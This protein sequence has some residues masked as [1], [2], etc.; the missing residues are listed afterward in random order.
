MKSS[1]FYQIKILLLLSLTACSGENSVTNLTNTTTNT[2][3]F[4]KVVHISTANSTSL[5]FYLTRNDGTLWSLGFETGTSSAHNG[6]KQVVS[7]NNVAKSA[8]NGAYVLALKND[9]TLWSWGNNA[10]GNLGDG[11]TNSVDVPQVV[12]GLPAVVDF[13]A[14]SVSIAV[15]ENG[16]VWTW[17]VNWKKQLGTGNPAWY[18]TVPE[19]IDRFANIITA[20]CADSHC[21]AVDDS[22]NLWGWGDN[23]S[24]QLGIDPVSVPMIEFPQLISG[25]SNVVDIGTW[26]EGSMA[27]TSD[28]SVWVW[29]TSWV[30]H[31]GDSPTRQSAYFPTKVSGLS[32]IAHIST[33]YWYTLAVSADGS[34]WG[35]GG[36]HRYLAAVAGAAP[37]PD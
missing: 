23:A 12:A 35:W 13:D 19:K 24:G 28:G 3:T 22:G 11:T 27:V 33:G 9:G 7:I 29:G 8:T 34:V 1:C 37:L 6:L 2:T 21:L 4:S 16:D 26:R 18:S 25:I 30:N 17:G 31:F 32:N 15:D 10:L 36:G 14:D 5:V 20:D